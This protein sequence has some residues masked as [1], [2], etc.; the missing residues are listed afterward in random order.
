MITE[1]RNFQ[2]YISWGTFVSM[3][4]LSRNLPENLLSL[5]ILTNQ[6]GIYFLTMLTVYLVCM[7]FTYFLH[8]RPTF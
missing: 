6:W 8:G 4:A 1:Q 3:S 2:Q 7:V 5:Q